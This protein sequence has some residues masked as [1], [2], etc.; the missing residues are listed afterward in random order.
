MDTIRIRV[1]DL[2]AKG[3]KDQTVVP[4]IEMDESILMDKVR[5]SDLFKDLSK[6]NIEEMLTHMEIIQIES[7]KTVVRQ[8]DE[9]DYYYL[10]LVGAGEVSK[11]TEEGKT[12]S[13]ASLEAPVGF[14]EEALISNAKRNATVTMT[15]N[16]ILMRL[17]KNNFGDYVKEPVLTWYAPMDAQNRIADG[18]QWIDVRD[19]KEF[20]KSHLHGA[21]SIPMESLRERAC[22]LDKSILYVCYCRNGRLSSTAAF[23]LTQRGFNAGVLRGGLQGLE[24]A[25]LA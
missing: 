4:T 7:G 5:Q 24:R 20:T 13:I 2:L 17:S 21:T 16:G 6:E 12:A 15:S 22:E 1:S 14:G 18:A 9:G 19:P 25:G 8:G 11:R 3:K 10:L 23:L